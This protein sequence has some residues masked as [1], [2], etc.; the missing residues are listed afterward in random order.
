MSSLH[1]TIDGDVLVRHLKRDEQMIDPTLLA[2]H[3]TRVMK[4]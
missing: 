3:G 1:R 4:A 2:R